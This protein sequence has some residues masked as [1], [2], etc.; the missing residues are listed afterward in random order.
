VEK[1]LR[2][3]EWVSYLQARS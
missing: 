2:R 1:Q 3:R